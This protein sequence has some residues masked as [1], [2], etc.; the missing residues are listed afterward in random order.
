MFK[1]TLRLRTGKDEM[2]MWFVY[3]TVTEGLM[4]PSV[5][6]RHGYA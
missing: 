6:Y 3:K 1:I 4:W 2:L 5:H